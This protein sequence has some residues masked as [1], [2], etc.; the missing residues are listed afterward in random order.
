M[1][2]K[3]KRCPRCELK[4]PKEFV[5]CPKCQLNFDKFSMATNSE[6]KE[7][8]AEGDN[9]RV[10]M[11]KGCPADMKKWKLLLMTIFLGFTGAHLYY[12]GRR[13]RGIFYTVFFIVGI[14]NGILTAIPGIKPTGD[15]YQVF[16]ML[17]LI[18][19]L[20]VLMWIWDIFNVIFNKFK[21]PVSLPR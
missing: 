14:I 5:I 1:K 15:L 3:N 18:W 6:A 7:A 8:L 20:V 19:G 2:L 11:R 21:I 9:A 4:V 13:G 12:V 10:L 16:Y 17:V